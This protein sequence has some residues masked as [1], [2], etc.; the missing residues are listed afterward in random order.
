MS[1]Y[2]IIITVFFTVL[3]FIFLMLP[4][5]SSVE[6]IEDVKHLINKKKETDLHKASSSINIEYESD[7]SLSSM[8]SKKDKDESEIEVIKKLIGEKNIK[9]L[10]KEWKQKGNLSYNIYIKPFEKEESDQK[11]VPPTMP[12]FTTVEISG[13]KISI[14]IPSEAKGYVVI[15]ED[16][17]IKYR[18]VENISVKST[19]LPGMEN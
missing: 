14:V 19:I 15:K 17:K 13:E 3:F 8:T 18:S 6:E 11:F 2:L 4:S 7:S 10:Y 9:P 12:S 16:G 5:S 1:R